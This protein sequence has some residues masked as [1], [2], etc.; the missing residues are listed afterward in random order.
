M[1]RSADSCSFACWHCGE[2]VPVGVAIHARIGGQAHPMCCQGCR[3]AAEWIEQLGLGDYYRLRT[4]P[5]QRPDANVSPASRDAWSRPEIARHVV[6]DLEDGSRETMLLVEGVRCA[7]CVW[8]IERALGAAPGVVS[9]QVNAAARRARITWREAMI[10]LPQI[11]EC[12][13]LAGYRAH[14]LD[15]A[16]LDDVRRRES[17]DALKRLLV[18]GFGAMQAMMFAAVLYLDS[19]DFS[20]NELFRW[21]GFLVATPVVFYSAQPFFA[22]ALRSLQARQPGMDVPVA[23]AVAL[24]Y[25]A[26]LV[27]AVRGSGHV[28]FDSVSMF[29]FFLLAGRYLEMR[30]RHRASDLTD[31]LARLTP[32]FADRWRADGV[33]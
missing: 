33:L 2:P 27:E 26:S 25:G 4:Q 28:Y 22:G 17:R 18:A 31:A 20:A 24:I 1:Q 14:P 21:L 12:L 10:T 3:A 11:L 8:L 30:A 32:P 6:R 5:A 15:A 9:V 19:S 16:A 23:A 29:V 13:A 7:A